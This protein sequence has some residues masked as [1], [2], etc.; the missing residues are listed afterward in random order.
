MVLAVARYWNPA[1]LLSIWNGVK[2]ENYPKPLAQFFPY[3]RTIEEKIRRVKGFKNTNVT[4][5]L[6]DPDSKATIRGTRKLSFEEYNV[7][8]FRESIMLHNSEAREISRF[9]EDYGATPENLSILDNKWIDYLEL[10][11]GVGVNAEYFRAQ[12]LQYGK[13][14]F[15]NRVDDGSMGLIQADFDEDKEWENHNVTYATL[16]WSD[17]TADIIGDLQQLREAY[18][19]QNGDERGAILLMNSR[20]WSWIEKNN[21]LN[22]LMFNMRYT[23]VRQ[24]FDALGLNIVMDDTKFQRFLNQDGILPSGA[25]EKYI[26]DGNVCMIPATRLGNIVCCECDVFRDMLRTHATRYDVDFEAETGTMV[27]CKE[28]DDPDRI[29]TFVEVHMFPRFDPG[30]MERCCVMRACPTGVGLVP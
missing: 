19:D 22:A 3:Q 30:M 7:P 2:A 26:E 28:M 13:F 10:M 8:E 9:I 6:C 15:R 23:N 17:P 14:T 16:D 11:N 18:K 4:L 20:T 27:R 29:Q 12:L 5:N 1:N 24:Y 21:A 25:Q